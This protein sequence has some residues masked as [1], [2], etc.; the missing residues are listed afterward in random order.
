M[1][2]MSFG[3]ERR[4]FLIERVD[5]PRLRA[6][7][8]EQRGLVMEA[9]MKDLENIR[10]ISI[11]MIF[12]L[13]LLSFGGGYL[14]ATVMLKPL[15]KLNE[16]IKKKEAENLHE[17][18]EFKDNGDEISQ[19]IKSFNRMSRRLGRSFESQKEFVE[20]ASHELKTPLSII[21]ANLDTILE[22]KKISKQELSLLLG[23]S[24]KQV[25][26]MDSLTEDL[27]LLSMIS[28]E[29]DIEKENIVLNNLIQEQVQDLA[30]LAKSKK[31]SIDIN[32]KKSLTVIGNRVLIGRVI[33]NVVE[34]AIKYSGGRKVGIK[35]VH[36]KES[37]K[38][39]VE[40]DGKGIP[41]D[42]REKIFERFVRVDKGRS[43]KE[44]GT[45]LGL[46]IAKQIMKVHG[47][48]IV[49]DEKY[50]KGTRFVISF[51]NV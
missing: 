27:L 43:R 40:D 22:D 25:K 49:L 50:R 47:G 7:S 31:I 45:G 4:G 23:N 1:N 14:I 15:D 8:E 3:G 16:E 32:L 33:S 2:D 11:Y 17:E 42:M 10:Q 5:R 37:I 48:D 19:L 21:Q 18:I 30:N 46:S 36:E 41:K 51:K 29:V 6:L 26:V 35:Q 34:N 9:R 20:N 38:L 24:K 12:P 13:V 39:F 28:S 44:G